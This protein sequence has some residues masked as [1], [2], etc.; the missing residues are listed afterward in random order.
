LSFEKSALIGLEAT[1]HRMLAFEK[2]PEGQIIQE[3]LEEASEY[4]ERSKRELAIYGR[5]KPVLRVDL[6]SIA[7]GRTLRHLREHQESNPGQPDYHLYGERARLL[8]IAAEKAGGVVEELV[9]EHEWPPPPPKL[10]NP[11]GRGIGSPP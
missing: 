3:L 7:L 5:G 1:P 11:N 4:P 8:R 2:S 10:T 9:A 6:I